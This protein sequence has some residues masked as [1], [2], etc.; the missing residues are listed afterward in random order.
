MYTMFPN[1]ILGN[2]PMY[3]YARLI[4][5]DLCDLSCCIGTCK[6]NNTLCSLLYYKSTEIG[7]WLITNNT[8]HALHV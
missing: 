5:K 7:S 4:S 2:G 1:Y 3:T 8:C 6:W